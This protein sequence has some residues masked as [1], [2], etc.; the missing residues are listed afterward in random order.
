MA[1]KQELKDFEENVSPI[2]HIAWAILILGLIVS[3]I[4]IGIWWSG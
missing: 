4:Y 1:S 3:L 2:Y